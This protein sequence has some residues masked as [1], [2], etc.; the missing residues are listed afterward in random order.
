M[1]SHNS[2]GTSGAVQEGTCVRCHGLMVPSFTDSLLIETTENSS[3]PALRCV[4]CGDWIDPTTTRM[5]GL[6][7]A[8]PSDPVTMGWIRSE[9]TSPVPAHPAKAMRLT[10]HMAKTR[11]YAHTFVLIA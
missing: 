9:M 2:S 3:A 4:N 1:R 8:V 10:Q 11:Q 5:A 7:S 6:C